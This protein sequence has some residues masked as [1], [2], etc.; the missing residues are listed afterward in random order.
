MTDNISAHTETLMASTF[1]DSYPAIPTLSY[2]EFGVPIV[3]TDHCGT[4]EGQAMRI[5]KLGNLID[6]H[7]VRVRID[8]E[9]NQYV[10]T[11]TVRID[12]PRE[13]TAQ[14]FGEFIEGKL[15]FPL[16]DEVYTLGGEKATHFSGIAWAVTDNMILYSGSR[17]LGDVPTHYNE[18][19][20]V[21][22]ANH[23]VRTTQ[24]YENLAYKLVTAIDEFR[25]S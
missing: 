13:I 21:V 16:T 6:T 12:T 24:L 19:I 15:V 25:V 9:G 4:W 1:V 7:S 3:F 11:N 14:Y 18:L 5:D 10:Q 22:N 23:R 2:N 20:T 17:T 8:I